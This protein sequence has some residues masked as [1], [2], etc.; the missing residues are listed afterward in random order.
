VYVCANHKGTCCHY[1]H[2]HTLTGHPSTVKILAKAR[3]CKI[4]AKNKFGANA[5]L[6]AGTCLCVYERGKEKKRL[7]ACACV[8]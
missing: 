5:L 8:V 3:S 4:N 1:T 6:C 2:T 7:C